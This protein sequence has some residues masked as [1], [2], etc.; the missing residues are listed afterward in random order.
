MSDTI[1]QLQIF[2]ELR[3]G[4]VKLEPGRLTAPYVLSVGNAV[5]T[6]DLIY[7][8][9]EP[10][11]D[12]ADAVSQNLASMMAVQ[13]ALNYGLFCRKLVFH[14][15]F[16]DPDRRFLEAMAENTAR[17]IYVKKFLEDNPFIVGPVK[18]MEAEK[19]PRY[20]SARLVFPDISRGSSV[21]DWSLWFTRP[22]HYAVLSSGGKDS[23]LTYGLMAE[24]AKQSDGR[25]HPI[26][27]NESGRHWFTALNAYRHF[28]AKVPD[29]CRVWVNSDRL[30]NWM[31]RHM[32]FVRNDFA[33]VRSDEYPIRLWTVA[34]F[35][36]A[37]LPLLRKHHPL[38]TQ[39]AQSLHQA[40][41]YPYPSCK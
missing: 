35:L 20:C 19:V 39:Y 21:P 38:L 25:V 13:A 2:D 3:V 12:P 9:E 30:F 29:T 32:P 10:V 23:L 16:D 11:F 34:V 28:K 14:G 5:E 41:T 22:D 27:I 40:R 33:N 36:F 18:S 17:E 24:V 6:F 1:A 31:L 15:L 37:A 8:F 26:F 7:R 4:P